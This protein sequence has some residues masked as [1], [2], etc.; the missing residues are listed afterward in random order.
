MQYDQKFADKVRVWVEGG[1]GGNGCAS[2]FR[3]NY[4]TKI[5]D[6]GD[7]GI[8]G[9]V[10]FRASNRISSLFELR[11]AHFKGNGGKSG[12]SQKRN[13]L[14]GKEINFTV[15]LGTEIFRVKKNDKGKPEL[16][17]I[18][19][20]YKFKVHDLDEEN[21]TFQAAKGGQPGIGN[22]KDKSIY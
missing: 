22:F 19:G 8:G 2:Y 6:G 15:P 20:E 21:A 7:G 9:S 10:N 4:G 13:G 1:R 17:T 12:K 3:E 14:S 11:R 5:P 16:G 18:E